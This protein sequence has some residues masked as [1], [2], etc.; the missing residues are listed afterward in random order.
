MSKQSEQQWAD[1]ENLRMGRSGRAPDLNKNFNQSP[2]TVN[3]LG[4]LPYLERPERQ[5]AP[6]RE[7]VTLGGLEFAVKPPEQ[8]DGVRESLPSVPVVP[9]SEP[10]GLPRV[11]PPVPLPVALPASGPNVSLPGIESLPR[12][13]VVQNPVPVSDE[14]APEPLVVQEQPVQEQEPE[15]PVQEYESAE[16]EVEIVPE[17]P[18]RR[19]APAGA[20]RPKKGEAPKNV[21]GPL[22]VVDEGFDDDNPAFGDSGT[23]REDVDYA[24]S[25][26]N[27]RITP[28]DLDMI[29]F[30]ARFRYA[31][32][33]QIARY[34]GSSRKSVDQRLTKLGKAGLL[35]REDISQGQGLWTPT[36]MGL[37]A[38]D[39]DFA[40]IGSGK[41]SPVTLAHTLGLVNLAIS[42]EKGYE[43]ILGL[44]D[45]GEMNRVNSAGVLVPGETLV[46]EREIRQSQARWKSYMVRTDMERAYMRALEDWR[47]GDVSLPS[48]EFEVGNEAMFILWATRAGRSDHIPDMVV[49]KPREFDGSPASLAIELELS[50][51]PMKEWRRIMSTFAEDNSLY[52]HVHYF[53]H[54]K[55]IA[56]GL[57]DVA[58]SV[59]LVEQ[60]RFTVHS[61]KPA[62]GGKPFWG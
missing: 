1:G 47:A 57:T 39:M 32:G 51:K 22:L 53:T 40:A 59:G 8:S 15:L 52:S 10:V 6:V 48:P 13:P 42:L 2:Q 11:K 30:L 46:S 4:A 16:S 44:A 36:A 56:Q 55:N 9:H 27:I 38:S 29:A 54:K 60:G 3:P 24:F 62:N 50:V 14:V 26:R 28:R 17:L 20:G 18:T 58:K 35:R 23:K 12:E 19:V 61:Y 49:T 5:E 7:S 31:Q 37:A 45:F 33:V 41:I 25:S 34:V 43:N 21:Q